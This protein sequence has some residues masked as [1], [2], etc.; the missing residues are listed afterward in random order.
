MMMKINPM[1]IRPNLAQ[2]GRTSAMALILS[3]GA[4]LAETGRQ[5]CSLIEGRLPDGCVQANAGTVINRPLAPNLELESGS[6]PTSDLGFSISIDPVDPGADGAGQRETIAGETLRLD[7]TRDVDRLFEQMGVQ[8]KFDGLGARPSLNVSTLD[9]RRSYAAG[10]TVTFRSSSNYPAWID[11]AEIHIRDRNKRSP[12]VV[13]VPIDANGTANWDMPA[14][15]SA[16]LEYTLRVYDAAGRYDETVALPLDRSAGRLADPELNGPIVAAGEAE[17][18]T[19]RRTIPVRGGAVTVYGEDVPAGTVINVMGEEVVPDVHRK[20]VMQRILPPGDHGIRIAVNGGGA[21]SEQTR[22]ITIPAS[23]WF[24]TGIAD[25]TLGRDLENDETY[26][27]GRIAGFAQGTLANGMRVTASVD[28]RE[29]ELRDLFSDFGRKYPDGMLRQIEPDEVFNTYGDD[30]VGEDLAPTSG[31]VYLRVDQG[32]SHLMWGD[33]K[34]AEDVSRLVRSDRTLYGLE[35]AYVSPGVTPAGDAK[36]RVSG[37]AAQPDS[38]VQRDILRG[39]GGSSYFLSRQDIQRG[40]ETLLIE[41]RD[42]VSGRVVETRRLVVGTDYRIDYVQGVVLLTA[43]LAPSAGAGGVVSD[44]PLGDYDVNLVAQYEYV[45]TLGGATGMTYG[46]R[47]ETWISPTLRFGVSGV[48][49]TTGVADN[50]LAGADILWR[51]DDL[52]FLSLDY[53]TSEGPGFGTTNSLNAGLDITPGTT[54]GALG[55]RAEAVRVEGS[56]DLARMGGEGYVSGYFERKGE[57]FVSPQDDITVGQDAWG[58]DGKITVA[59]GARLTFGG[60]AFDDDA[61]KNRMDARIGAEIDLSDSLLL[62]VELDHT[63]RR[64]AAST[65]DEDNGSRTTLGFK[66]K[67]TLNDDQS[68]WVFGQATLD[69]SGGLGANNRLGIGGETRFSEKL[70]GSGEISGGDLGLAAEAALTYAPNAGTSYSLGYRLDP[71][72]RLDTV[73][74]DGKDRGSIVLGAVSTINDRWA[75]RAEN[76]YSAFGSQPS[77]ASTYGLTYT[78]TDTW[79]YDGGIILGDSVEAD[80][81]TLSRKGL[82]LGVKYSGGENVTAGLRGELRD[83]SSDAPAS[84]ADR[85]TYLASGFYD[86][87]TSENWRLSAN[88]DAVFSQSDQSS[89][90]DG[91][92]VEARLGY[93]YRP[94][95]ND[96]MNALLSYTYLYDLPGSDQVNVDGDVDGPKQRSHIVNAA[97]NYDLNPQ[98]TL[99]LKYGFRSRQQAARDSTVFTTA[100]S[101]LGIVRL[102][103]HV[104]SNWDLMVEGRALL[105]PKADLTEFG[106]LAGVYRHFGNN[107]RAG[108]GYNWGQVSDDLRLIDGANQGVFLN[109]TSQF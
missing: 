32:Q 78:P 62:A 88:L 85:T 35:G 38:L 93:A 40:S 25:L 99:G 26:H 17:D 28:T 60:E 75:Y 105:T 77:L 34:A 33:F 22:D 107:L 14:T 52:T 24:S 30:S 69:R 101:H 63:K 7:D 42:P 94:V 98:W 23:E 91:T 31:K 50:T 95:E 59:A 43:P 67:R 90:L 2:L 73:G 15:G 68:Y 39:T 56:V 16:D 81:S 57:G 45:P 51:Q 58:I 12:R 10:D 79:T 89:V 29:G 65:L 6:G 19:A 109:L 64:F 76:T 21:N 66:L 44:R 74:F 84:T 9:M 54:A 61:G 72:R 108:L 100:Q 55:L 87:K 83:E 13:V 8:M 70:T 47:A 46:G 36:I 5:N 11:R 49:E 41:L 82:S 53:A 37:F 92:Y 86:R 80:G 104:V 18:R 103:Y 1:N 106:A 102:D 4:G 48:R 3:T 96:R 97:L 20:F 27:F 71:A